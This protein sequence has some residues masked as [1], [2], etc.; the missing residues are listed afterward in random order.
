MTDQDVLPAAADGALEQ[1]KD[2]SDDRGPACGVSSHE[3]NFFRAAFLARALGVYPYRFRYHEPSH[4][5]PADLQA[6]RHKTAE[7]SA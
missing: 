7:A 3:F 2:F 1:I 5:L 4:D 6:L